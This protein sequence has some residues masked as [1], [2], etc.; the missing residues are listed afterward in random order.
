MIE[1]I[2]PYAEY[3]IYAVL[4]LFTFGLFIVA[5]GPARPIA[6]IF[7]SLLWPITLPIWCGT[8]VRSCLEKYIVS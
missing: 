3:V 1:Y 6:S 4:S 2:L 5:P 7:W 8:A